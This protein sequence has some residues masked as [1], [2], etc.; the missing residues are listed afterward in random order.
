[1]AARADRALARRGRR[2]GRPAGAAQR[3]CPDL[4]GPRPANPR[5][6]RARREERMK[7]RMKQPAHPSTLAI[8]LMLLLAACS[9]PAAVNPGAAPPGGAGPAAGGTVGSG[10]AGAGAPSGGAGA[11][12]AEFQR[13]LAAA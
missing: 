10:A 9:A 6:C 13:V 12:S 11:T 4:T 5:R 7:P 1:V 8:V 2:A 3:G